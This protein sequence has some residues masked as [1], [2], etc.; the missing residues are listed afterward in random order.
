MF[1]NHFRAKKTAAVASP[2]VSP[3]SPAKLNLVETLG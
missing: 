1:F 3:L 2:V